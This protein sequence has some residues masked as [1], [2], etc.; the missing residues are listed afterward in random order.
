MIRCMLR[1]ALRAKQVQAAGPGMA[2][3]QQLH[4]CI[5]HAVPELGFGFR[6]GCAVWVAILIMLLK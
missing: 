6:N 4:P 1:V 5:R 2:L 3:T